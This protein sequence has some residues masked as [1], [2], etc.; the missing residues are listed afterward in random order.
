MENDYY[1]STSNVSA[2][3]TT[4]NRRHSSPAPAKF[5]QLEERIKSYKD[6][7]WPADFYVNSENL[8]SAGFYYIGPTDRVKCAFCGGKLKKW[9]INDSPLDEHIKHFPLCSFV[10]TLEK[11]NDE[12]LKHKMRSPNTSNDYISSEELMIKLKNERSL[13]VKMNVHDLAIGTLTKMGFKPTI[14]EKAKI[15]CNTKLLPLN[16][17]NLLKMIQLL[18]SSSDDDNYIS[19]DEEEITTKNEYVRELENCVNKLFN[20]K[21]ELKNQLM[22]EKEAIIGNAITCKVCLEN[23]ADTL[24]LTCRH[25]A[26][27]QICANQLKDCPIC[28]QNILGTIDVFT[29]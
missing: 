21:E 22:K 23:N 16:L 25:F 14:I 27:C 26:T 13:T 4:R 12:L 1:D 6:V 29:P 11:I 2:T 5:K 15:K 7:V 18:P 8:S 28:R 19:N 9:Q 20:E 24:F 3:I 17:Q 10:R